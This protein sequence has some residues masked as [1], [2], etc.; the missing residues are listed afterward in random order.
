MHQKDAAGTLQLS[1]LMP[2]QAIQTDLQY[3]QNIGL[4]VLLAKR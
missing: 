2:E 3:V 1:H 4:N